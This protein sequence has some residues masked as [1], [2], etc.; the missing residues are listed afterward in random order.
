VYTGNVHDSAGGTTRCSGCGDALIVRD[1]HAVLHYALDADSAC[2]RCATPL[3]GRFD[4]NFAGRLG[5]RR[6]P[7]RVRPV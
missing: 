6:T 2:P 5:H 3:A 4:A 1:W 7:M